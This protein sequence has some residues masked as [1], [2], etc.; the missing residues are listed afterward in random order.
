MKGEKQN[1]LKASDLRIIEEKLQ[2]VSEDTWSQIAVFHGVVNGF[3]EP[4]GFASIV[5]RNKRSAGACNCGLPRRDCP[6]GGSKNNH[7]LDS[8]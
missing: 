7:N 3:S 1:V 5:G 6:A 8:P 4:V 2:V